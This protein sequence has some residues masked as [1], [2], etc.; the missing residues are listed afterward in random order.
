[1][2]DKKVRL[3]YIRAAH[4]NKQYCRVVWNASSKA[5]SDLSQYQGI[6]TIN[7]MEAWEG[8]PGR[9]ESDGTIAL[10]LRLL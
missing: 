1:M 3:L 8:S 10:S 4:A 2:S 7:G 5:G 9:R 6:A